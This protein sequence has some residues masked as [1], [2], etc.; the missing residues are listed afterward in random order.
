MWRHRL[1][2]RSEF[3][4]DDGERLAFWVSGQGPA[5]ILVNGF[6]CS[7]HYWPEWVEAFCDRFT[8]ISW[9]YRGYGG[10]P[11]PRDL[12]SISIPSFA[13]DL[14][15][16][17]DSQGIDKALLVGHSMGVQVLFDFV[18][19][20]KDRLLGL[21]GI[22]GT[23][24][25][26]FASLTRLALF[27]RTLRSTARR[28]RP[29]HRR[30]S[31]LLSPF[32]RSRWMTEIAYLT[33]ANRKL[34][35]SSYLDALFHHVTAMDFEVVIRSF[36]SMIEHSARDILS[37]IRVPTLLIGGAGDGVTPPQRSREIQSLIPG[38]ECKIYDQC[39]HL[40]MVERP[41]PIHLDT[42]SWLQRHGLL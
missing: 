11:P 40:A 27:H 12:A 7:T 8:V 30:V 2:R 5:M 20:Y 21:V 34:L 16:L 4:T 9:D 35:P 31:R 32:L 26:P 25:N 41:Q 14:R 39:T 19:R 6:V 22:C 29:H 17:L 15:A 33:G 36:E 18:R 38:S 42:R 13:N 24:E 10:Q 23:F 37:S 1:G 3:Q 28:L